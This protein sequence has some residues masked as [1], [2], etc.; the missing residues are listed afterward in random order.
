M[1]QKNKYALITVITTTEKEEDAIGIA[2]HLVSMRLCACAQVNGPILSHYWW[3]GSLQTSK[4]WQC[5]VKASIGNYKKIERA[6]LD[7]H[8]YELPQI[9]ALPIVSALPAYQDWVKEVTEEVAKP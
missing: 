9:I 2:K 4:E 8:P 5:A 3:E 7:I 6:I 1:S